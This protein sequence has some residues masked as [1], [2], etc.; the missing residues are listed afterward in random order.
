M[1]APRRQRAVLAR[2]S[3]RPALVAPAVDLTRLPYRA[4]ECARRAHG[5]VCPR[6]RIRRRIEVLTPAARDLT[7]LAY[8]TRIGEGCTHRAVLPRWN[9]RPPVACVPP[10]VDIAG[11]PDRAAVRASGSH[12]SVGPRRRIRPK[13][14]VVPPAHD[15]PRLAYRA[16]AFVAH[17][18]GAIGPRRDIRETPLVLPPAHDLTR[19]AYPARKVVASVEQ[20]ERPRRHVHPFVATVPAHH[21]PRVSQRAH[22]AVARAHR[23]VGP[24][25]RAGLDPVF[26]ARDLARIQHPAKEVVPGVD[27]TE[28]TRGE[29]RAAVGN[30]P[31]VPAND[32]AGFTQGAHGYFASGEQLHSR[33]FLER[34]RRRGGLGVLPTVSDEQHQRKGHSGHCH[35]RQPTPQQRPAECGE[36]R[37]DRQAQ[38]PAAPRLPGGE[39][40][41][42]GRSSFPSMF[43]MWYLTASGLMPSRTAISAF[44]PPTRSSS[45]TRCSAGVRRSGWG[46]RPRPRRVMGPA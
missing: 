30:S 19:L 1:L 38:Q 12:R 2:W 4:R 43:E 24:R 10:A 40:M 13:V 31:E 23:T 35:Q 42:I 33:I 32:P 27:R 26:P 20:A 15:F 28:G 3:L 41:T 44:V 8:R 45:S 5:Q 25:G 6:G 9:V 14:R 36:Y 7:R 21:L 37:R 17:A 39:G 34:R 18:E 16:R 11:L 46:G 29:G 22:P